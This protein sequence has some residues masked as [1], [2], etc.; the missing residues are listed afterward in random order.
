MIFAWS[1][2]D[3]LSSVT[4]FGAIL[5]VVT[6]PSFTVAVCAARISA[7]RSEPS[8]SHG[9]VLLA[10]SQPYT[11]PSLICGE[12]TVFGPGCTTAA[13]AFELSCTALADPDRPMTVAAT[14]SV[15]TAAR[16]VEMYFMR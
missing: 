11:C 16:P 4:A 7:R 12:P 6:A 15:T 14:A 9:M 1:A 8:L 2:S 3:S 10:M 5:G 13:V